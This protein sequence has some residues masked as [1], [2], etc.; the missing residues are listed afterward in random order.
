[1]IVSESEQQ[2]VPLVETAAAIKRFVTQVAVAA[3]PR[4]TK[5]SP[6][7]NAPTLLPLLAGLLS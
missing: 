6:G 4:T 3:L 1:M 2:P 7:A 5:A